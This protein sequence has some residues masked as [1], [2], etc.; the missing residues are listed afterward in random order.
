MPDAFNLQRGCRQG[1]PISPYLFILCAEILDKMVRKDKDIKGIYINGK[2]YKLS[3]YAD[4]TQLLL[5][6]SEKSLKAA[7][8]LLKQF[9]IMSGLKINVDKTRALWIGSSCGSSETLCDE[10]A[11]DWSQEPLKILGVT[12]SPLV[13]NIWDLNSKEILV[14]IKNILNQWSKRKLSLSGK[15]TVIKFLAVS[16]FVHLFISLPAPPHDLIK[17]LEKMFYKFL[18]NSGPDRIKRQ[19]VIKNIGCAGL[20]MIEL[21]SFVKALK[22]SWLRRILQQ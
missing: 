13:F 8:K 3:Q 5:D 10:L 18:W 6:G 7:I 15:I 2:E 20:K 16:K 21:R 19:I 12:F 17:E 9:Y 11:L 4:D 22:L 14:K 1:D